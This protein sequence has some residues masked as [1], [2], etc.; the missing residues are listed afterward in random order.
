MSFLKFS[1]RQQQGFVVL[2]IICSLFLIGQILV[3]KTFNK[4]QVNIL[5]RPVDF[6]EIVSK[7]DTIENNLKSIQTSKNHFFKFNP[8]EITE[9]QWIEFGVKPFIAKRIQK[10]IQKHTINSFF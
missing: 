3:N 6:P 8:N 7:N 9:K 5:S 10:Y 2:V 1:N 4:Q